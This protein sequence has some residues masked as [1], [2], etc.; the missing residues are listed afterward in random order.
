MISYLYIV[1][2]SVLGCNTFYLD[3]WCIEYNHVSV[4]HPY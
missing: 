3:Q 1:N 4:T 2:G